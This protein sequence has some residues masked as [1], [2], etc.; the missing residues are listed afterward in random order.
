MRFFV[1]ISA[2]KG[3]TDRRH[4]GA[5]ILKVFVLNPLKFGDWFAS[6]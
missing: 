2:M 5:S 4:F 3:H 6:L 1:E